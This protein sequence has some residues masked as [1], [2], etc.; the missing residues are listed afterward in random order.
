VAFSIFFR[1]EMGW[2]CSTC[3]GVLIDGWRQAKS[4]GVAEELS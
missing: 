4:E 2:R 1:A 3:A